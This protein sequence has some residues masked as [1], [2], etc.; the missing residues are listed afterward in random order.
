MNAKLKELND[1]IHSCIEELYTKDFALICNNVSERAI[2][3][4]LAEYLQKR[5][6]EYHVDC[7]YNRN[8]EKGRGKP[9]YLKV[10]SDDTLRKSKAIIDKACSNN[11]NGTIEPDDLES[12]TEVSTYPDIIVHQRLTNKKN[13]IVIE[14]KK[15]N[16]NVSDDTDINKLKAFTSCNDENDY[17]Y[18]FGVFIRLPI[19]DPKWEPKIKWF[20][21]GDVLRL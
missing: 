19:K 4:K 9:K 14:V 13:L 12:L 15:D 10:I 1:I 20:Q 17:K 11:E 8:Y 21:N 16:S 18:D 7:E 5:F 2:T 3:H 6:T